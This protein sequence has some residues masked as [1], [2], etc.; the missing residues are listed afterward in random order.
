MSAILMKN[1]TKVY[2]SGFFKENIVQ[3]LNDF[4]IR[5]A[6][7]QVFGVLGPNGAGKSTAIKILL[8]LIYPTSGIAYVFDKDVADWRARNSIGYVPEH[9]MLYGY[10]TGW[11]FLSLSSRLHSLPSKERK[12]RIAE[13]LEWVEMSKASRM[14]IRQYSKGMMQRIVLAQALVSQPQLLILDEP[15]SGL[16][17][18]GRVKI[19]EIIQ[20]EKR[21]NT[22]ILFCTH[23][24][25]DAEML[26][27]ELVVLANGSVVCSGSLN[28]LLSSNSSRQ[29]V[30]FSGVEQAQLSSSPVPCE[31]L[32]E[33]NDILEV[34]VE[35]KNSSSFLAFLLSKKA[36]IKKLEP[37]VQNLEAVFFKAVLGDKSVHEKQ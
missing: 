11:E 6:P 22:T 9:P 19:R 20:R 23:I 18:I 31:L 32:A 2:R 27:D 29:T 28:A 25:S 4:S 34:S 14:L 8:G 1:I 30:C 24:I 33:K 35:E 15:T 26:C 12:K 21:K 3:A 10:L 5:V 17:P 36:D 7:G 13:V 37:S 16:D